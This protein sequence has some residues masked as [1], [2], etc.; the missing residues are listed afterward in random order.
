ME[1]TLV[2]P[3]NRA[4]AERL[5]PEDLRSL[6]R[7]SPDI[8]NGEAFCLSLDPVVKKVDNILCLPWDRG[9]EALGL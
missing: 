6:K 3:M 2:N 7:L 9:L 8:P 1:R 4:S 5:Q